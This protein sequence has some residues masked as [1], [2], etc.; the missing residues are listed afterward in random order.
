[1]PQFLQTISVQDIGAIVPELEL[2]VFGM[3]LLIFDLLVKEKRKLGYFALAGIA[4]SAVFLF[5]L[6]AV[7]LL[8]QRHCGPLA[9]SLCDT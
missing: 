3:F 1:M 2:A 9:K 6:R 7:E 8:P 5:R 4:A